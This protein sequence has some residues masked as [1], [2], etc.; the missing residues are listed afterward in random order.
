MALLPAIALGDPALEDRG[1]ALSKLH[2]ARCHVVAPD[3]RMS[4][5]SSTPSF[6][7]MVKAL[8]DWRDRFETFYARRPH[9]AHIRFDTDEERPPDQPAT[10]EEVML[11][12]DDI[13]AI[14]AYAQS[15][16]EN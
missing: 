3:D 13:D 8:S 11:K 10:I 6:M 7:I 4:G 12:I 1:K 14:V 15:L 5:I 2:C 16:A 9:P